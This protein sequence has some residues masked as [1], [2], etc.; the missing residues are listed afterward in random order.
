[1]TNVLEVEPEQGLR[2]FIDEDKVA[3]GVDHEGWDCEA[4]SELANQDQLDGQLAQDDTPRRSKKPSEWFIHGLDP[5]FPGVP[6]LV[7]TRVRC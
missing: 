7:S 2:R 3:R 6:A 4:V 5:P 1:L